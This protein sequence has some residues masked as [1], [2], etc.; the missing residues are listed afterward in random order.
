MPTPLRLLTLLLALLVAPAAL[1]APHIHGKPEPRT[2]K[3][4][5]HILKRVADN[6]LARGLPANVTWPMTVK[7]LF[8]R[9][10]FP[11]D[12]N[13]ATT[14]TGV[15]TDPAYAYD[16]GTGADSDYWVTQA[17]TRMTQFYSEASY[18]QLTLDITVSPSVYRLPKMMAD[19]GSETSAAI[20]NLIWDSV[21]AADSE[22]DFSLYD[23]LLIVH[24]GPG[25]E[26]DILGDSTSDIWSLYWSDTAITPNDTGLGSLVADGKTITDAI[27]MPQT[28]AQDSDVIDPFGVYVHEFGHW[29]GLPD[30]YCVG[31]ICGVQP[32]DGIGDWGLM[33]SGAYNRASPTDPYGSLPARHDAWSMAYLG[34]ITPTAV[35]TGTDPGA[36]TL[37]PVNE[38]S[39]SATT[40]SGRVLKIPA[41]PTT[42]SQYFLLENRQLNGYDAG[43]PG[44]G[45]LVWLIDEAIIGNNLVSNTVNAYYARPGLGLIEADGTNDLRVVEFGCGDGDINTPCDLGSA[46]DPFPGSGNATTLSPTGTPGSIAYDGTGWVNIRNAATS[47]GDVGFDLGYGP[48]IAQLTGALPSGCSLPTTATLSWSAVIASDVAQ[49]V[50]YSVYHNGIL[51][52]TTTQTSYTVTGVVPNDSY[53]VVATDLAGNDAA[54]QLILTTCGTT[55]T[56]GNAPSTVTVTT[57]SN[58]GTACFIATAAFGSFEAP[59]VKW[60]RA[61]RD[62][63]LLT[64]SPGRAFVDLYYRVSPPIADVIAGNELL[65]A[66]V[67]LLLLPFIALAWLLLNL[68]PAGIGLSL[69]AMFGFGLRTQYKVRADS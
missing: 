61:F 60:L 4:G 6:N 31:F 46:S 45:M 33:G 21:K 22:I 50:T 9:V 69:L 30:L 14:G 15:W 67:R 27:L 19:Y 29:L 24:A 12:I 7:V 52:G 66:L 3:V 32:H 1:A 20:E 56:I 62:R 43:L 41:S 57:T 55:V 42:T 65:K 64:H 23:A 5:K 44:A 16:P 17:A 58:N 10:D 59:A 47:S 48:A 25:E 63:Y 18:G 13:T 8:L 68:G 38:S 49:P 40:A 28:G 35:P 2:A 34:W 51:A 53:R 37:A 54:A 36:Q 11:A 39:I 26:T